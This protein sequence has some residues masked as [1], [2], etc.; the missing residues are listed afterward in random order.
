MT[1]LVET[2]FRS[3]AYLARKNSRDAQALVLT[4]APHQIS[5]A[6]YS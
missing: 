4:Q 2:L 6:K 5:Y 1:C 3:A